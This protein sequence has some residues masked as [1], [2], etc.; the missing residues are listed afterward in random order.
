MDGVG[1]NN[2]KSNHFQSNERTSQ[3]IEKFTFVLSFDKGHAH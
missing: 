3:G 2:K 1:Q